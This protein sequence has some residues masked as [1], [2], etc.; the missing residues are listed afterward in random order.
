[1]VELGSI[2]EIFDGDPPHSQRVCIAPAWSVAELLRAYQLVN[3]RWSIDD[4]GLRNPFVILI[5]WLKMPKL[6]VRIIN[7]EINQIQNPFLQNF[8]L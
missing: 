6:E 5:F 3:S 1:M 7:S 2:S 8:I 4:K